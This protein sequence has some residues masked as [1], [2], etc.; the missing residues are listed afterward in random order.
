MRIENGRVY[1]YTERYS[2]GVTDDVEGEKVEL[3]IEVDFEGTPVQDLCDYAMAGNSRRV[4]VV[5]GVLRPNGASWMKTIPYG[6]QVLFTEIGKK[7]S[8]PPLSP[9]L[10]AAKAAKVVKAKV[11]KMSDDEKLAAL[12]VLQRE[13]GLTS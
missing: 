9:E 1:D 5:N 4:A 11:R 12:E 6:Y 8:W 3:T 10:E 7:D 2:F 13:L